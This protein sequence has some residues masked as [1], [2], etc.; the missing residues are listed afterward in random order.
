MDNVKDDLAKLDERLKVLETKPERMQSP[1]GPNRNLQVIATGW[2]DESSEEEIVQKVDVFRVPHGVVDE[3]AADTQ[4][5]PL[6][7][8]R[9][10]VHAS[11][12]GLAQG[13]GL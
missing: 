10:S 12:L 11:V 8:I 4:A 9:C 5:S 1:D 6:A 7:N 13:L 2:V 3:P